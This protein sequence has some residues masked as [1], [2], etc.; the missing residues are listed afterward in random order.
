MERFV[1]TPAMKKKLHDL[2][3]KTKYASNVNAQ[4]TINASHHM[5]EDLYV[6]MLN[7]LTKE[8]YGKFK[9]TDRAGGNNQ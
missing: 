7:F 5:R 3:K 8:I 1:Y 4:R 2:L 9:K 6:R